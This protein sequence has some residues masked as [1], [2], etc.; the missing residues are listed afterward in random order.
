MQ[1]LRKPIANAGP[2]EIRDLWSTF[3]L[4]VPVTSTTFAS[5]ER[6]FRLLGP[7]SL[8]WLLID[9]AGQT[10][11]QAAVGAIMRSGRVVVVG[12]PMQ[13]EPVVTLP[14][15]LVRNVCHH[16][17]VPEADFAAPVASVQALGDRA[18]RYVTQFELPEGSRSVGLPLLVHRR[19]AEPM[20]GISNAVAYENLM[21]KATPARQSRIGQVLRDSRWYHVAGSATG[22]WCEEEGQVLVRMLSR[23]R[24]AQVDLDLYVISP[25]REVAL[26]ARALLRMT[27]ALRAFPVERVGTI[28]T[29][30][31]REAEAVIFLLGAPEQ[32]QEGARRWA[33]SRPNLLN[34]AV[35]RAKERLYV[36][37]NHDLWRTAGCFELLANRLE[38]KDISPR[39]APLGEQRLT[40]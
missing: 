14:E 21:V 37:G 22:H 30:Q 13:V 16:F 17:D 1:T 8:G 36:V 40:R 3:A 9:E 12:D 7:A 28:H 4:V 29:V 32:A 26:R 10:S 5:V 33:G 11:P 20:F 31:G 25:F 24:E 6:M 35:T 15:S 19:C 18:S 27:T 23:L 39:R 2:D 38:R 34:V